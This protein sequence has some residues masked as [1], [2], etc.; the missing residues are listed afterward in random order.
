MTKQ[1]WSQRYVDIK[2][3]YAGLVMICMADPSNELA[4]DMLDVASELVRFNV[5]GY[6]SLISFFCDEYSSTKKF[7]FYDD[8]FTKT[9]K[10]ASEPKEVTNLLIKAIECDIHSI[11]IDDHYH[12]ELLEEEIEY[13]ICNLNWAIDCARENYYHDSFLELKDGHVIVDPEY[14]N[15]CVDEQ[16]SNMFMCSTYSARQVIEHL[17]S[18][19][20]TIIVSRLSDEVT[21]MIMNVIKEF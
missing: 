8:V 17:S 16:I 14:L 6:D 15:H 12:F 3:I 11:K 9:V 20:Y 21:K 19:A 5:N 13:C 2:K 10:V 7:E 18:E 4:C 1:W